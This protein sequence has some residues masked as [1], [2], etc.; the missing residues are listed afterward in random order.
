MIDSGATRTAIDGTAITQLGVQP[1][2]TT[3]VGTAGGPV[4]QGVYPASLRFPGMGNMT[5]DFSSVVS[6]TLTGQG[7]PDGQ[8]LICLIGRD[9]L[10]NAVLIYNGP[11][12][13]WTIAF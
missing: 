1:I 2:S 3:L 11:H 4:S 6:V 9:V 12:S 10:A 13:L 8:P 7:T 5:L